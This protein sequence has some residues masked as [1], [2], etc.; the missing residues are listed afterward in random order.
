K[1][2]SAVLSI[3]SAVYAADLR[4]ADRVLAR[5]AVQGLALIGPLLQVIVALD[6]REVAR[7]LGAGIRYERRELLGAVTIAARLARLVRIIGIEWLAI[8]IPQPSP[9]EHG[10]L[11]SSSRHIHQLDA[12]W[13]RERHGVG[14]GRAG[15]QCR[16][17]RQ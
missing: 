13:G 8:R 14:H 12:E 7:S 15:P 1:D 11:P 6:Q 4:F 16:R 3:Q 2:L 5:I 10:P 9:E 17:H